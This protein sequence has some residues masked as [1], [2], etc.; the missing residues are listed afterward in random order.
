MCGITGFWNKHSQSEGD[1]ENL[2]RKM[3]ASL[4]HRGPDD[5]CIWNHQRKG[6]ALGH[7]RL[8]IQDLSP[9]GRQPMHSNSG[10]YVIVY[11]GEIYNTHQLKAELEKN[12]SVS[13]NWKGHSDTEVLLASVETWGLKSAV[14]RFIGMFAFALWDKAEGVLHL[15]R[16]RLGIKPLYYGKSGNTFLF[17]SELKA[18]KEHPDFEGEIDR[19]VLGLFFRHNYIPAPYTIYQKFRK[20][21][22]GTILSLSGADS[23]V[24]LT[25]YWD[26]WEAINKA[27]SSPFCGSYEDAVEELEHLL[28]DSIK[29]RMLSDVPLGAFLSGGI[30]SSLVVALMQKQSSRPVRT[31]SIGFE[32]TG[33]DEAPFAKEV[34]DHIGTDHTELYVTPK[35]A[36]EV[37]PRLATIY[38]EPF[39]DSSQ[40][41]TFLVSELAKK[42]VTV[43]LS[44][45]GGDELFNGYSRY[46]LADM[47]WNRIRRL[48]RFLKFPLQHLIGAIPEQALNLLYRPFAPLMPGS[49]RLR[50]P[51]KNLHT[52]G[53]LM[54]TS[55]ER[56]LYLNMVSHFKNPA[57]IVAGVTEPLTKLTQTDQ[58][59]GLNFN[60]WMMAQDLVSYLPD[61]I[62][63]KVDRASM[64]VSLEA[65]VPLLDHRVV[66]FA[67]S[68]PN[69]WKCLGKDSKRI[70]KDVLYQHVPQKLLDRPKVGFGVPINQ[71]LKG[72]LRDWAESLIGENRLRQEG[73]LDVHFVRSMWKEH[74]SGK[75]NW[76]GQLWSVL[77]FQAWFR[78]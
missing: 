16:D 39:S 6:L 71:W 19:N 44:G 55:D 34:A 72:P 73:F 28:S 5:A 27:R 7:Q 51:G 42:H 32:D 40:I 9:A 70:L 52:L 13:R 2:I 3:T 23:S 37:I 24:K 60:E 1:S 78:E 41:P 25:T 21:E 63:T 62:L 31:F 8:A 10:R 15:V 61:D 64:A 53:Q 48:P 45:D 17:G 30:D 77:M 56:S 68:L 50:N 14:S 76:Q 57:D 18:L 58:P 20:L 29:S 46:R 54:R 47:T 67:W 11:N 74:L 65:R 66:E 36:Q 35:Q 38:D 75:R 59:E 4:S 43:A 69:E 22:P 12:S 26:A 33:Y 49:L